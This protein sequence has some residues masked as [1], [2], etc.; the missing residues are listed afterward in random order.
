MKVEIIGTLEE[1][2]DGR[3]D[4]QYWV[5][6]CDCCSLPHEAADKHRDELIGLAKGNG[7][8]SYSVE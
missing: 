3:I 7:T 4:L 2:S 6:D 5:F 1:H 8:Y